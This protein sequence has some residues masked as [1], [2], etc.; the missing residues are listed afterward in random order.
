MSDKIITYTGK[1]V[2]PFDIRTTDVCIEDIAHSLSL[3]C[4]FN[5]HC[6]RFYSVAE[7]CINVAEYL[8]E[9][10]NT[11][12]LSL[13]G[14]LHDA[15]ETY[16]GDVVRPIKRRL[17]VYQLSSVHGH[18]V[19]ITF[20]TE[21]RKLLYKILFALYAPLPNDEMLFEIA[22]AND[23]M[24]SLELAHFTNG[25]RNVLSFD[26]SIAT[27][28]SICDGMSMEGVENRFLSL[29]NEYKQS[30]H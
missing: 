19:T 28:V 14:L 5:G 6:K 26:E 30:V 23:L 22:H 9:R 11:G 10:F 13:C 3:Q 27:W 20:E 29:F 15:A 25:E 18:P 24:L 16:I 7:H 2:D 4:R 21:E 1:H 12:S 8:Q 17:G